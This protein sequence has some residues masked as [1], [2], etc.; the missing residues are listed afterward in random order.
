[1]NTR[2]YKPFISYLLKNGYEPI[3]EITTHIVF[4]KNIGDLY[5]TVILEHAPKETAECRISSDER[6][7]CYASC[8]IR[9]DIGLEHIIFPMAIQKL[10]CKYREMLNNHT[11]VTP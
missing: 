7:I 6:M 5:S 3:E 4:S 2:D 1:M 11:N 9:W 10:I 8:Y